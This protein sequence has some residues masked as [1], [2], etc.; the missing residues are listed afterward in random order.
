MDENSAQ[1]RNI[2]REQLEAILRRAK[3]EKLEKPEGA[4]A[5]LHAPPLSQVQSIAYF[6]F[7]EKELVEFLKELI[8][9]YLSAGF[10]PTCPGMQGAVKQQH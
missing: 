7:G 4:T 6:D 9:K 10:R 5:D 8:W 2:V 3:A 1:G